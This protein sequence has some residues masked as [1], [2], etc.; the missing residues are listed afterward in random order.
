MQIIP[1]RIH[2]VIDY[3]VALLLIV[4]PWLFGFA[5]TGAAQW[6]PVL[7]GL[8]T[9]AYSLCT[10]YELGALRA[11]PMPT[12]LAIDATGGL[13]LLVSPWLFG[14][15]EVIAWPHVLVG[16]SEIAVV[17]LSARRPPTEAAAQ[18]RR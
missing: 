18:S 17:A 16:L 7:L 4:A 10:D 8:G 3:A 1:T 6:V 15:A 12:H 13:F 5:G 2:G 9:I 14:F 11:I